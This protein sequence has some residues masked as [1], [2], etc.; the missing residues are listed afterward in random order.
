MKSKHLIIPV[1][2][3]SGVIGL[4]LVLSRVYISSEG[5]KKYSTLFDDM[6]GKHI[7]VAKKNGIKDAPLLN[8]ISLNPKEQFLVRIR[9]SRHLKVG[10]LTHSQP[11]LTKEAADELNLIANDFQAQVRQRHLPF[12]RILV[13]S[14]LRTTED[15]KRL[16]EIN[17]NATKDSPHMYGT[18]FD[19]AWAFFQCPKPNANGDEYFQILAEVLREHRDAQK[20]YV[21]YETRER[22]FHI[23][24]R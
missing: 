2:C 18:T 22:C 1:L 20:I 9:S 16:Q 10:H 6:Q 11:Y 17:K 15:V 12:C 21:R 5:D 14:L 24:V 8:P 23:T 4:F 7:T 3:I 13:T 19:I